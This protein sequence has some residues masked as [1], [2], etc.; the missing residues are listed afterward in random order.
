M[1]RYVSVH[2]RC[3][4]CNERVDRKEAANGLCGTCNKNNPRCLNCKE[5]VHG[6]STVNGLC[7]PCNKSR[8]DKDKSYSEELKFP[9]KKY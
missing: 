6:K 4:N 7:V 1:T 3:L 5:R 2:P 8:K 9:K